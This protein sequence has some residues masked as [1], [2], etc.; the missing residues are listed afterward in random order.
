MKESHEVR[1]SQSPRPRVMRRDAQP[2]GEAFTEAQP[3]R[4]LSSENIS[5]R[6]PTLSCQREGNSDVERMASSLS[7]PRS[8][9]PQARLETLLAEAGRPGDS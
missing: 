7:P 9:R 2:L 1:P 6:W 4:V 3:G 8:L 5:L